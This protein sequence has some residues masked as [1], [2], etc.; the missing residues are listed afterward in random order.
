LFVVLDI[1][2][3]RLLFNVVS[4]D[5]DFMVVRLFLY[6]GVLFANWF[7]GAVYLWPIHN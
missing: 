3:R 7:C 5:R 1:A 6:E 2:C 4:C